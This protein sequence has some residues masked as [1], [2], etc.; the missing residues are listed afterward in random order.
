M[1]DSS[2]LIGSMVSHYRVLSK[3]GGGGMGVVYE[4][5]DL[6]LG[7]R[8]ALKFLPDALAADSQALERFQREARS[9]SALNHPNI[10][11]IYEIGQHDGRPYLAME[12]LKGETLKHRIAA[13]PIETDTLLDI[14][15][16]IADGLDAAHT[17]GIVHRDIKPA[18]IFI[19]QRGQTKILDFGLAKLVPMKGAVAD[20]FTAATLGDKNISTPGAAVGTVAYMSPEQ[21]RAR[22]VD[23][24]TDIFSF[25]AVIY[26]MATGRQAFSGNSSVEIFDAILNRAPVPPV[27]LNPS[28]PS[29]LE[30]IINKC[31]EKDVKLR[32]QHASDLRADLQRMQRDTA[33]GIVSG[34]HAAQSGSST[35][36]PASTSSVPAVS[37]AAPQPQ[38]THASGSSVVVA[39]AKQHKAA[40]IAG[41]LVAL[42]LI[43]GAGYGLY[44]L[45][46]NRAVVI[47]F[48]T[49]SVTQITNSGKAL[50]AAISPDGKYVVSVINENGKQ[51]LWLRNIATGSNTQVLPP[52]S[53]V[54]QAVAFSLDAN[55]IFYRKA[56]DATQTSF[57]MNRM[58]VLGG[59]PQA[60]LHD[61][62]R[63]PS[64]SPDGKRMAYLRANDPEIG[65]YRLLS[66]NLDGSDEKILMIAPIPIPDALSWSPDGNKIAF[67][68]YTHSSSL[69]QISVF[70]IATGKEAP[71]AAF[72]DRSFL[73]LAWTPDGRGL[74]ANYRDRASGSAAPQIAFVSFP[75]G[76]LRSL[77]NDTR[78]YRN[79]SLSADASALVSIQR[80][81]SDSVYV[82]PLAANGT[83]AQVPG[84]PNQAGVQSV[85]W[86]AHGN[87]L[88]TTRNSVVR[89]SLD[90]SQQA[91]LVSDPSA[92]LLGSSVCG[93]GG[94]I[95]LNW[96]LKEGKTSN[97]IWRVD[98]DGSHPKQLT[99]GKDDQTPV[100]ALDG[101]S[102]YYLENVT[103]RVMKI[104]IDGGSAELVPGSAIPYSIM[105][106]AVGL[107]P[108]GKW[109]PWISIS[110][111]A[112][113]QSNTTRVALVDVTSSSQASTKFLTPRP[114]IAA[115]VAITPDGKSVAYTVVEN[116]VGNIWLQPVDGSPG[117][118]L[119]NFTAD[120]I[121][122][123]QF[124]PDGKF[125]AVAR[126]HTVAD[127][128]LL[129]DTHTAA[130]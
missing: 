54:I 22:E 129:R 71:L 59:T 26:E 125:V 85:A 24:R 124:S 58:P 3:L 116:G 35:T 34:S 121:G 93:N 81:F 98:A 8:V 67:V 96:S 53:N 15:T 69:A 31:L 114:D 91:T 36:L 130:Q 90:G 32:Y 29:E 63:G 6:N 94:P 61:V 56:I 111:D 44:S 72:P 42:L 28:V 87:L 27:R 79:L 11:T 76:R 110:V 48:Q 64:F 49:F 74:L 82:Q 120:Q 126:A 60:L 41:V 37:A 1:T 55:Y 105:Q 118:R 119:T 21:A 97:N 95:L 52:D 19:T 40:L 123:F 65:K 10:C 25:G 46:A 106:G 103:N 109:M 102:L 50:L 30:H 122:T 92:T 51:S 99:T 127:V 57:E 12:M 38:A 13:G 14:S 33:S 62:D 16:Q 78:G 73:D 100:C 4:A 9:A 128:V 75:E 47:P 101:K 88:V 113:T 43:L 108:D 17:E 23:A 68:S 66:A 112:A 115:T 83:P 2:P 107:S 84:L 86:D 20:S 45:L 89:M 80:Q 7:R 70:D 18:N 5:E 104:P 117:H 77:T 39:A